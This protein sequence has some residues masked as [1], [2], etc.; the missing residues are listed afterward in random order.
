MT[1][2]NCK[3]FSISLATL[4]NWVTGFHQ[5]G[6]L[7]AEEKREHRGLRIPLQ[8]LS[9]SG[10]YF[11]AVIRTFKKLFP[12]HI[13]I[14]FLKL[15][16]SPLLMSLLDKQLICMY[17]VPVAARQDMQMKTKQ[18]KTQTG[19]LSSLGWGVRIPTDRRV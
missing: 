2:L 5:Q 19:V 15:F 18:D 13:F 11:K 9:R 7:K 17:F 12:L 1:F 8:V 6:V 3:Y 4:V 14:S 10:E 16:S